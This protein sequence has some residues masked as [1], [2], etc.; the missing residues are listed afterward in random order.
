MKNC[1]NFEFQFFL[2]AFVGADPFLLHKLVSLRE[3]TAQ[4]VL[5]NIISSPDF[6]GNSAGHTQTAGVTYHI[7]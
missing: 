4:L 1:V 3:K 6:I 7:C 2:I 5:L